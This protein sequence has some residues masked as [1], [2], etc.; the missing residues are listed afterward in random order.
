[1]QMLLCPVCLSPITATDPYT[2]TVRAHLDHLNKTCPMSGQPL[3]Q[4]D[5]RS[6]RNAVKGRSGGICEYCMARR[7]TDMHHRISRGVGGAWHPAN[8]VHLCRWCHGD[9]TDLPDWAYSQGVSLRSTQDPE[10]TPMIRS[11]GELLHLTDE[12]AA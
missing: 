5:E 8:I 2:P 3:P 1:M 4:W 11:S 9:A 10:R 6:T 7:A 12:V